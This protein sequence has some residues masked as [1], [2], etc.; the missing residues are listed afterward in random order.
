MQLVISACHPLWVTNALL[1]I[2][3]KAFQIVPNGY[4][5]MLSFNSGNLSD[6]Q[7]VKLVRIISFIIS[8]YV[9]SFVMIHLNQ[10]AVEGPTLT[11][12]QRVHRDLILAYR[13][14][15][16]DIADVVRKYYVPHASQWLSPTNVALSVYAEVPPYSLRAVTASQSFLDSIDIATVLINSKWRL[17]RFSIK[18]SKEA[19]CIS[20]SHLNL[21]FWRSI[22]THNRS[23]ERR[24]WI[25]GNNIQ[26]D[27]WCSV[28]HESY[29]FSPAFVLV[30]Y[31]IGL[32]YG[33]WFRSYDIFTKIRLPEISIDACNLKMM[34]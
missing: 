31:G 3:Q 32:S 17:K 21:A 5:R 29:R 9:P 12:F 19:P 22:E 34:S 26:K 6:I 10:K 23:C 33:K 20:A 14:L 28:K 11:L 18:R 2:K 8:A 24:I 13:H 30:Q 16:N 7:N 25:S 27:F 1:L 4:L 15:D